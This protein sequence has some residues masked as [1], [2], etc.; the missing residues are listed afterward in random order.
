MAGGTRTT[1]G[2]QPHYST[3]AI[4]TALTMRAVFGLALRQTKGLI[5]SVIALLGL[6]L[7][8]PDHSTMSRRRDR[9]ARMG[10]ANAVMPTSPGFMRSGHS[11]GVRTQASGSRRQQRWRLRWPRSRQ[12]ATEGH[13]RSRVCIDR[14]TPRPWLEGCS[15]WIFASPCGHLRQCPGCA[16]PAVSERSRRTDPGL[17]LRAAAR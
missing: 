13:R 16:G 3:L 1:P 14:S 6:D 17:R 10:R 7:T 8:V 15:H 9:V 11:S 2:G 4:R 12:Y 5:G